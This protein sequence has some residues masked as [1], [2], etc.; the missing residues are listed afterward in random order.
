LEVL[1]Y[2]DS[3]YLSLFYPVIPHCRSYDDDVKGALAL[4]NNDVA[5]VV[6]ETIDSSEVKLF[7]DSRLCLFES[8][9]VLALLCFARAFSVSWVIANLSSHYFFFMIFDISI[10]AT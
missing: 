8:S 3:C 2:D 10:S 6:I 7:S 5:S 1:N 4:N 9:E